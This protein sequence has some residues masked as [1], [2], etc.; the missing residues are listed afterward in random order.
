M[1]A[2]NSIKEYSSNSYYHLYNRGVEKRIIFDD[3]KDYNV[4][5]LYLRQYLLP[6]DEAGLSAII[7]D[8]S[9]TQEEKNEARKLL[10]LNNFSDSISLSAYCFM[11]NHFH[12][13]IYQ[14]DDRSI[15]R[16]MNS[17][18]TRYTMYFN[19]RHKRVGPLFQGLYKAVLVSSDEQLQHVTRYIHRNPSAIL[20]PQYS[21]LKAYP[22]SSYA[23]YVGF[24]HSE[25]VDTE[26]ILAFFSG[27]R[28]K[29]E[30]FVEE[31][32]DEIMMQQIGSLIFDE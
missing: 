21:S 17:L 5:L 18:F 9:S 15:D 22:Y 8:E 26:K 16:F 7:E 3:S 11:P 2:K 29:Y 13:L 6:K 27:S 30:Q 24:K 10:R 32:D 1:P 19:S 28:Q 20:V 14:T 31:K 23:E 12:L 4:F 25:W